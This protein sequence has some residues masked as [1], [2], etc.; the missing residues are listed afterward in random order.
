MQQTLRCCGHFRGDK[1]TALDASRVQISEH[2]LLLFIRSFPLTRLQLSECEEITD[3]ALAQVGACCPLL[4]T[5]ELNSC[6]GISDRGLAELVRCTS[7]LTGLKAEWCSAGDA[8]LAA[9]STAP[10]LRVVHLTGCLDSTN[11]GLLALSRL[12]EDTAS[13]F[14]LE[15]LKLSGCQVGDEGLAPLLQ[16]CPKLKILE[17]AG[18]GGSSSGVRC[19]ITNNTLTALGQFCPELIRLDCA[20]NQFIAD[21]GVVALGSGVLTSFARCSFPDASRLVAICPPTNL[22]A[23]CCPGCRQLQ[24]LQLSNCGLTDRGLRD[25]LDAASPEL[26]CVG[27]ADCALVTLGGVKDGWRT[28]PAVTIVTSFGALLQCYLN[29]TFSDSSE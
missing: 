3:G 21:V 22:N 19:A 29:D 25:L 16:K 17:I 2:G 4:T 12:S 28:R 15:D 5:V 1:V 11:D 23:H 20:Q 6:P 9:L 7:Q 18:S 26:E 13:P 10:E 14:K 24:Y 8:T 27:V